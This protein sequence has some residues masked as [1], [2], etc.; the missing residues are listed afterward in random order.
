MQPATKIET[1]ENAFLLRNKDV[2]VERLEIFE[3][4]DASL[5]F[6]LPR[7]ATCR[8]GA[9]LWMAHIPDI[10]AS[11][12]KSRDPFRRQNAGSGA[13]LDLRKPFAEREA[14]YLEI[15]SD[16]GV[17]DEGLR[18]QEQGDVALEHFIEEKS[19]DPESS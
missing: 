2:T 16:G 17:A 8:S 9:G 19:R 4:S 7:R 6:S 12:P 15:G 18:L 10:D 14:V 13:M 1:P 5:K 11:L 3:E